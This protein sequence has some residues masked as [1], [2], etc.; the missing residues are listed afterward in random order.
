MS[1]AETAATAAPAPHD[2]HL[3]ARLAKRLR[4]VDRGERTIASWMGVRIGTRALLIPLSH[5]S[6]LMPGQRPTPVPYTQP[7][8]LG[9]VNCR[10]ELAGVIDLAAYID[11]ETPPR[12]AQSFGQTRLLTFNPALEINAALV[13][14][15]MAGLKSQGD[16][17]QAYAPRP[18]NPWPFLGNF[19]IDRDGM[20]WQELNLQR[21]SEDPR[22]ISIG[23]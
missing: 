16:F 22:F 14:D 15:H 13:I 5:A 8:F 6:E 17:V 20:T 2:E 12:H 1:T 23:L 11:P 7:W 19:Y 18:D 3:Q 10:G 21:L 9:L 4:E